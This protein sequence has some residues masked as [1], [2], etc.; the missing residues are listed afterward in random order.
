MSSTENIAPNLRSVKLMSWIL[1]T[2]V[3]KATWQYFDELGLIPESP[4][5]QRHFGSPIL[6]SK[7]TGR[8]LPLG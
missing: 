3:S 8:L 7:L 6:L 5:P 1:D 2:S 4:H